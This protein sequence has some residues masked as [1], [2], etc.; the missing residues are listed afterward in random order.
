MLKY[1]NFIILT[2][3]V[4]HFQM[5]NFEESSPHSFP[6]QLVAMSLIS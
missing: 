3:I 1:D 6:Q 5:D 4:V 2:Q